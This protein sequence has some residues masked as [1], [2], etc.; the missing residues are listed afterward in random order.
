MVC[1]HSDPPNPD[2]ALACHL[3]QKVGLS[4]QR[5]SGEESASVAEVREAR[6]AE[7]VKALHV[8]RSRVI[9]ARVAPHGHGVWSPSRRL[10]KKLSLSRL[11][12]GSGVQRANRAG[13]PTA[14]TSQ[15][16][17]AEKNVDSPCAA[18]VLLG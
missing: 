2:A 8:S 7:K 10:S 18:V 15:T 5:V 11:F 3:W 16:L 14:V 6:P 17:R 9:P 1:D 4:G 12:Q 13:V